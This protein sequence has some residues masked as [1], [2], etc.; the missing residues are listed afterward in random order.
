MGAPL[1]WTMSPPEFWW[2]PQREMYQPFPIDGTTLPGMA[3]YRGFDYDDL[4]RDSQMVRVAIAILRDRAAQL[5][6][7]WRSGEGIEFEHKMFVNGR[8]NLEG[9]HW[10]GIEPEVFAA[11]PHDN[12]LAASDKT[13]EPAS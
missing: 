8:R 7:G 12:D 3:W 6:A 13:I 2:R 4:A 5:M 11:D 1:H 10:V 9:D